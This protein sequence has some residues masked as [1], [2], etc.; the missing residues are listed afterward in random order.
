[1]DQ[2][3]R[4]QMPQL[5]YFIFE[6]QQV[7]FNTYYSLQKPLKS[8]KQ[9]W[10]VN[11]EIRVAAVQKNNII[12][13][14]FVNRYLDRFHTSLVFGYFMPKTNYQAYSVQLREFQ[15]ELK[16]T[17]CSLNNVWIY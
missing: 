5:Q 14:V 3:Y 6:Q 2:E 11:K 7:E 12:N 1:M 15:F 4:F 9:I 8:L 16:S 13:L 17:T 10:Q